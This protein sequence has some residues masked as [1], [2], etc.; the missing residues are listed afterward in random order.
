MRHPLKRQKCKYVQYVNVWRYVT[1]VPPKKKTIGHSWATPPATWQESAAGRW[2]RCWYATVDA[3]FSDAYFTSTNW[4]FSQS[5]R[6]RSHVSGY[7]WIRNFFFPD[8]ASFHSHPANSTANP[9]IFNSALQRGNNKSSTKP[10]SCG[11]VNPD[12]FN[13]D[14]VAN[15]CPVSYRTI[16]QY[17]L[18]AQIP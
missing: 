18:L 17:S 2:S 5:L 15:S 11:R 7:F 3:I 1:L 8:T 10:I 4:S 6:P 14:D 9:D 16:N 12:I 13:S